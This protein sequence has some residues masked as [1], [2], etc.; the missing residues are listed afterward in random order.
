MT[1][2]NVEY[3]IDDLD[4]KK[5]DHSEYWNDE[6]QEKNKEWNILNGN[7]SKMEDY[8]DKVGLSQD[9]QECIDVLESEFHRKLKG[10]GIDLG[11][12]NLWAA[13]YLFASGDIDKLYCL[14][15]AKHRLLKLGPKVLEHYEIPRD[16]VTLVLGS[17]YDLHIADKSM[18]FAFLSEAF[19]HADKPEKL[20]NEINRVLTQD[21]IV[22]II[23]EHIV[24]AAKGY[25]YYILKLLISRFIP[26]RVQKK[27]LGRTFHVKG[28]IPKP[29]NLYPANTVTGDHYY[30]NREYRKIFLKCGFKIKRMR[31]RDSQFQS[32][33]LLV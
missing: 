19:H 33:I 31:L 13:H 28:L 23:G 10:I 9:L 4:L 7:F 2:Y 18:D 25:I 8:L 27:L 24:N 30:T 5:S 17:F 15:Y 14:E 3:W 29:G 21:G 32:F 20:L 26:R 1:E 16:K 11:A 12:G 22:I 6:E